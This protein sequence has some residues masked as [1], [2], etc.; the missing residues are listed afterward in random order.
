MLIWRTGTCSVTQRPSISHKKNLSSRCLRSLMKCRGGGF[1]LIELVIVLFIVGAV[2][3]LTLPNL[4]DISA[5]RL[6]AA[7]KKLASTIKYIRNRAVIE[8]RFLFLNMNIDEGRYYVTK[9]IKKDETVE[10]VEYKADFAVKGQFPPQVHFEDIEA[11]ETGKISFGE[12]VIHFSPRGYV[13]STNIH[14]TD[15]KERS[16]TLLVHPVVGRVRVLEGYV[17]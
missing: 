11:P 7:S 10:Y 5:N 9:A 1:T 12:V 2:L 4:P 17:R 6:K 3:S 8:K 14:I 16:M 13:E 15:D